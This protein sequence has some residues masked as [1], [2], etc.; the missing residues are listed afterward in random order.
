METRRRGSAAAKI[1]TRPNIS[2]TARMLYVWEWETLELV[3]VV[4]SEIA[5]RKMVVRRMVRLCL[6]SWWFEASIEPISRR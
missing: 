2:S 5:R 4:L 1:V 6:T 3:A